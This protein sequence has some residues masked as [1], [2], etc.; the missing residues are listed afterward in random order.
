MVYTSA[1][2]ADTEDVADCCLCGEW[3]QRSKLKEF[4]SQLLHPRCRGQLNTTLNEKHICWSCSRKCALCTRL[5]TRR[6]QEFR[7]VGGSGF[8]ITGLC[9]PCFKE[10]NSG[11]ATK[12]QR[13]NNKNT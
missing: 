2:H 4:D 5:I 11:P 9:E 1:Y 3:K 12:K 13:T 10:Q 6:Q 8:K 7:L